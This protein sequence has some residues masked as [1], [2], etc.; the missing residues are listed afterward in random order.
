MVRL[1]DI[2][3][4]YAQMTPTGSYYLDLMM[5][6]DMDLHISKVSRNE[7]STYID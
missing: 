6:P 3:R 7:Q 4:P 5:F 1:Y 2:V